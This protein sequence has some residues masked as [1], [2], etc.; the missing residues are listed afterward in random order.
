MG[1]YDLF[2]RD[3]SQ[4]SPTSQKFS[5][6][7]FKQKKSSH[8]SQ[9]SKRKKKS[10]KKTRVYKP[11]FS[12]IVADA[13][14]GKILKS[15]N[16][17][18]KT[19]PA[20]LTKMMT[21]YLVFEALESG[22]LRLNQKLIVSR[23]ASRQM[24]GKLWLKK[25]QTITVKEALY[26]TIVKSANDTAVVLAEALGGSESNFAYLMT[27]KAR[28]LGMYR[29]FFR[30]AS[31]VPNVRQITTARDM[32]TLGRSL[33]HR[34]PQHYFIFGTKTFTYKK[35]KY[36]NTNKLL[37]KLKGIDGIK[38][39]YIRLSGYNLVASA[40]RKGK[41]II[42]VVMGGKT[43]RWRNQEMSRLINSTFKGMT[44]APPQPTSKPAAIKSIDSGSFKSLNSLQEVPKSHG[45]MIPPALPKKKLSMIMDSLLDE[46]DPQWET[47]DHKEEKIQMRQ[48]P[49][50]KKSPLPNQKA[51]LDLAQPKLK[52]SSLK[53][54]KG[55]WTVQ[56][57]AYNSATKAH[58][59]VKEVLDQY[60]IEGTSSVIRVGKGVHS[61]Y[62]ARIKKLS[63]TQAEQTCQSIKKSGKGC[64]LL[65]P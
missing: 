14:S 6:K 25:G 32:L 61:L 1:S 31:G 2:G 10:R 43:S 4:G 21:A 26:A 5:K 24:S 51:A 39:G 55:E 47:H 12:Y 40:I 63:K 33:Y 60:R 34:F 62:K 13:A 56:V 65:P 50:S 64:L 22:K 8:I 42:A 53:S 45:F 59:R 28:Q 54:L 36:K 9:K 35:H 27:R 57:G 52:P 16:S 17:H 44:L 38:T 37:G 7:G 48:L 58:Q 18:A 23:H 19:Y 29:T 15:S 3:S 41:R 20:S 49:E 30:N 11:V 46:R